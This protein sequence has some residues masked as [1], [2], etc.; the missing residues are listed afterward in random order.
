MPA[1]AIES[2]VA[3]E[4]TI[5]G[6]AEI[7]AEK[8][9][10]LPFEI[11][12][13]L[14]SNP[15]FDVERIVE[16]AQRVESRQSPHRPFGDIYCNIGDVD[17]GLKAVDGHRPAT[18]ASQ[19][20]QRIEDSQAWV[21]LE[22]V[23]REEGYRDVLQQSICDLLELSGKELMKKI[24]WFD[25]ILFVTSPNRVT[26]YHVDRECAWLVQIHGDK[27][28]HL[29]DKSDKE[30]VP[31]E[32][33]ERFW[34]VD[35]GAG[36]YKPQ[37]EDRAIVFH[38]KPGTGVHIPVNCPHWLKNGNEVSVSMNVNFQFRDEFWGNIY[39][40]NHYLRRLGLKP[41][42]PGL[43]PMRDS[44]KSRVY[45]TVQHLNHLRKRKREIPAEA[46]ADYNRIQ[47]LLESHS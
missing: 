21:T 11:T 10:R 41:S 6:D 5:F 12:H 27:D 45:T 9:N 22:H 16:L 47:Q 18:P 33:L 36:T 1:A 37:F 32:E 42:S 23:E 19:L 31:D 44:L 29:F 20:L 46:I 34:T 4:R 28:I 2:R 24:K 26:H 14:E 7:F 17:P 30:I 8:F 38:M 15:L 3:T 25:A 39:K 40:A 35:N 13:T 43:H